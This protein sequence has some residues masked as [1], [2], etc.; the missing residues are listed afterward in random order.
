MPELGASMYFDLDRRLRDLRESTAAAAT[1]RRAAAARPYGDWKW[2]G[3]QGILGCSVSEDVGGAGR[4]A[5][6]SAAGH[7]HTSLR[8][9][10]QPPA[11]G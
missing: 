8:H 5:V 1:E 9:V 11:G 7:S 3:T 4:T 10:F 2:L 6:V